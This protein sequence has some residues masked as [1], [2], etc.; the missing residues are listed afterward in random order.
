MTDEVGEHRNWLERLTHFISG[1]PED[2][3]TENGS[4]ETVDR[5]GSTFNDRGGFT[6]F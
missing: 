5:A 6:G 3:V 1:E 2:G 4:A